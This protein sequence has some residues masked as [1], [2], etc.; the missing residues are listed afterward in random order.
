[1]PGRG[2]KRVALLGGLALLCQV[3]CKT[4][5]RGGLSERDAN[6]I[7]VALDR[8]AIAATKV[9]ESS[10]S[11]DRFQIEVTSSDVARAL[12]VLEAR[13]LPKAPPPGFAELYREPGLVAT[14]REERTRWAAA[15][16][17]ELSRSLGRM[18]GV[19]EARV[20]LA[21]PDAPRALDAEP[22]APKAAVLI[23][24]R[25]GAQP[26]DE[27]AVRALVAGAV[28]GLS[29]AQVTVVQ[30][31][32]DPEPRY[33]PSMVRVGPI[34]VTAG[35]AGA[36]KALLGGALGLDVVLAVALIAIV[37]QRPRAR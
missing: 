31:V 6:Q 5:I 18:Q 28:E 35:S 3:G 16:A 15:T 27:S 32:A 4:S 2:A 14:P 30:S 1:M 22:V 21:L 24:R 19:L 17:G 25:H 11:A 36:L 29:A 10:G 20:H 34:N 23:E 37:R 13:K 7:V 33:A 26:I 9:A 8:V 12:A